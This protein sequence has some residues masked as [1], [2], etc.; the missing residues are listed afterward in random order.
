SISPLSSFLAGF[1]GGSAS[2][3]LLYPLD[4]IKVRMQVDERRRSSVLAT[5]GNEV[6]QKPGT[7]AAD[8]PR[9]ICT[10]VKGVIRHEGYAGLY[11]GLTPAIIGSAA[12]WG[13][14]FILYEEMKKQMLLRKQAQ[15]SNHH[16][17]IGNE[18]IREDYDLTKDMHVDEEMDINT[19]ATKIKNNASNNTNASHSET[20]QQAKLGPIE[21]FSA[22]CL[23]GACMV[24]LTNPLWLI[25]TRLQLQNS[26]LQ[27]QISQ[28]GAMTKATTQVKPAY[29]G[30]VHAAYTIVQEEGLLALYKGSVPAMMLV[31]HGGIQFVTYEFMKGHF[32][33][34][35]KNGKGGANQWQKS[36]GRGKGTIGERLRDSLGYLVM[37]AVSKFVAS[38]TTYPLQVIKARLQQRSQVVELSE[39]GKI[40]VTKREYHGVVDCVG[41]I[42]RN[43]GIGG[44]F[45]GCVTNAIRVAPSAAITFVTYE[46]VLDTL[47]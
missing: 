32:A 14:F 10:T 4:L 3:I 39:T 44:F 17:S 36:S 40:V 42:W 22:S 8:K 16:L 47:T 30:L 21:H 35:T 23:A 45:K 37:G 18:N 41:K 43:E 13:G 25:K 29:R 9:T 33:N 2:T 28:A 27:Q 7:C 15:L 19:N 34:F 26:R 46:F 12:S 6:I 1:A 38:T 5:G 11:R 20:Q 24:A 31:S